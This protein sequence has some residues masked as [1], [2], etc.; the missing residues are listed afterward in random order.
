MGYVSRWPG[1]PPEGE[2]KYQFP[3]NFPRSKAPYNLY[4]ATGA[5][6]VVVLEGFFGCLKLHRLGYP[7]AALMGRTIPDERMD[8]LRKNGTK[9]VT[10]MLDEDSPGCEAAEM[11][12]AQLQW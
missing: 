2:P 9:Y 5:E 11:T 1:E 7:A 6:H 12:M 8:L 3:A 10:L 4:R